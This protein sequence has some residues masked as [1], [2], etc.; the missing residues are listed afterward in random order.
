MIFAASWTKGRSRRNQRGFAQ[1]GRSSIVISVTRCSALAAQE[2]E[3]RL[4]L[5]AIEVEPFLE[6]GDGRDRVVRELEQDVAGPDAELRG[7]AARPDELDPDAAPEALLR[8]KA[9]RSALVR[10]RTE[11]PVQGDRRLFFCFR[12]S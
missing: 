1:A 2:D 9:P 6:V 12:L 11:N 7:R 8:R 10:G 5:G 3:L 4:R